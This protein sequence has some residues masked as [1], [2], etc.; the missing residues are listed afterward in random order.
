MTHKVALP[1]SAVITRHWFEIGLDDA[2]GF[3][4]SARSSKTICTAG[5]LSEPCCSSTGMT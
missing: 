1:R 2:R 5:R 3:P 4:V